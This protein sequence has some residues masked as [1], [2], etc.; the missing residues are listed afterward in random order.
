VA[1]R[2]RLPPQAG[3]DRIPAWIRR[4]LPQLDAARPLD[5]LFLTGGE[6]AAAAAAALG[7]SQFDIAAEIEPG[8]V[9]SRLLR[10]SAPAP[11]IAV[12][13]PGA[14][15]GKMVWATLAARLMK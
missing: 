1:A 8:I 2:L 14:Y 13:K 12:T 5:G 4:V 15:G 3:T 9:A 6:T 7:V 10:S 11:L